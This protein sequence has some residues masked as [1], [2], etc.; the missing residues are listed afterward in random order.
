M[1]F[2]EVTYKENSEYLYGVSL[3]RCKESK[4]ITKS[5]FIAFWDYNLPEIIATLKESGYNIPEIMN[6]ATIEKALNEK[7][8]EIIKEINFLITDDIKDLW[9]IILLREDITNIKALVKAIRER[10]DISQV[11]LKEVSLIPVEKLKEVVISGNWG[12]IEYIGPLVGKIVE[13]YE[14][15]GDAKKFS[16]KIDKTYYEFAIDYF[17]GTSPF[18]L[19]LYK[20]MADK[21]N[22]TTALRLRLEEDT[23]TNVEELFIKEGYIGIRQLK[24]MI[25]VPED[26]IAKLMEGAF[27]R[28]EVIEAIYKFLQGDVDLLPTIMDNIMV[29]LLK[30]TKYL[31]SHKEVIFAYWFAWNIEALNIRRILLGKLLDLPKEKVIPYLRNTYV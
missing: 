2:P 10:K 5:T 29:E 16:T 26:G 15:E 6:E 20:L 17:T 8:K 31:W 22:L 27:Y 12:S 9:N 11:V 18:L 13:E 4:F 25:Y 23:K 21:F 1:F 28:D 24:E 3:L 30:N 19:E 14:K 7:A